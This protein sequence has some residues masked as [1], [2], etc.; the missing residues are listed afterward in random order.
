MSNIVNDSALVKGITDEEKSELRNLG[1]PESDIQT[2]APCDAERILYD[3]ERKSAFPRQ[4]RTAAE[5]AAE[6]AQFKANPPAWWV[7]GR[8]EEEERRIKAAEARRIAGLSIYQQMKIEDE[9]IERE[10]KKEAHAMVCDDFVG[11]VITKNYKLERDKGSNDVRVTRGM[12]D[13]G[14]TSARDTGNISDIGDWRRNLLDKSGKVKVAPELPQ[15]KVEPI[16]M[17]T[18]AGRKAP[19]RKWVIQNLVP[20][21]NVTLL[22]A[23]GATGKSL[24]I[25]QLLASIALG[26]EWIG[27][28]VLVKGPTV[29][30]TAEDEFDEVWRRAEHICEHES[31]DIA[32][33]NDLH[34]LPYAGRDAILASF[35][36]KTG[37][38]VKTQVWQDLD[39]DIQ[40]LR[41]KVIAIDTL[42][43]GFGGNELERAQARGFISA[44][45]GL[46]LKYDMAVIVLAHPSLSGMADGSGRSGSTGWTNSVRSRLYFSRVFT[47]ADNGG[48]VEQLDANARTLT[49]N[50]TN[51]AKN[52]FL[53]NLNYSASVGKLPPCAREGR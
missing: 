35:D 4:P 48:G 21:R 18:M 11:S 8:R 22:T 24:L 38:M 19:E 27:E 26:R 42:A 6:D 41:P 20:C 36:K 30:F 43:D 15:P 39:K 47:K 31:V 49:L 9:R 7:E 16:S 25:L 13:V 44:L 28:T 1:Y 52:G 45:R 51:Y 12:F 14:K 37:A 50:K 33:M 17:A 40:R 53:I 3:R 10:I 2:M 34:V 5:K 32:D 29:F 46:A 23:D